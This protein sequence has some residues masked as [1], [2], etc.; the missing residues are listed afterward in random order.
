MLDTVGIS[1]DKSRVGALIENARNLWNNHQFGE[2][3][4]SI[5]DVVLDEHKTGE[6]DTFTPREKVEIN[7]ALGELYIGH[8]WQ[9]N[10]AETVNTLKRLIKDLPTDEM[11]Q[12]ALGHLDNLI[13]KAG[14]LSNMIP[15]DGTFWISGKCGDLI[16]LPPKGE[17]F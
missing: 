15:R 17:T 14:P 3:L 8:R 7:L 4:C 12:F 1:T 10:V 13:R 9:K 16:G 11:R 2:A 6:Y 5:R